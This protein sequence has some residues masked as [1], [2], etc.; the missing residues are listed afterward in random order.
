[1]VCLVAVITLWSL[2]LFRAAKS[3]PANDSDGAAFVLN[4]PGLPLLNGS[5]NVEVASV[6]GSP[7][8]L[9]I[10]YGNIH[11][12]VNPDPPAPPAFSPVSTYDYLELLESLVVADDALKVIQTTFRPRDFKQT[13]S[14]GCSLSIGLAPRESTSPVSVRYRQT[15][16]A[17]VV[18]KIAEE[19]LAGPGSHLGG[20]ARF[21]PR[22]QLLVV[23][24]A[25][26]VEP[27]PAVATS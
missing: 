22:L 4:H 26:R 3:A 5:T 27:V 11:C 9:S 18:A 16:L 12:L 8:D 7:S 19:C 6:S 10:Q 2:G 25:L 23:L 24:G 15:E 14:G 1:M 20:T 13:R 21:G 17:H